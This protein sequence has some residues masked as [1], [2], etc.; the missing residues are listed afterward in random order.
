MA[1]ATSQ[2]FDTLSV[3]PTTLVLVL[4]TAT[5]LACELYSFLRLRHVPGPRF[6]FSITKQWMFRKALG[7]RYHL[8]LKEAA[9]KY[10]TLVRIGPDELLCTDPDVIRRMS[11]VRSGYTKGRFY[12]SARMMAGSD[13]IISM[14][15]EKKHKKLIERTRPAVSTPRPPYRLWRLRPLTLVCQFTNRPDALEEVIDKHL[16]A[17]VHL[18]ETKYLS[19]SSVSGHGK[20]SVSVP[21]DMGRIFQYVAFDIIGELS[22]SRSFGLLGK[23]EDVYKCVEINEASLGIFRWTVT[24]PWL[25]TALLKWPLNLLAPKEGDNDVGFVRVVK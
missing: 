8:E 24:F 9:D 20:V 2:V 12:E 13:N 1:S 14:R 21:V 11:G 15:D 6:A 19:D 22:F 18:I 25:T 17:L 16:A 4:V 7:D 3:A 23:G 5:Y 10:G